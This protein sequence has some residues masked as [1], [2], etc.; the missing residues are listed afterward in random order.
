MTIEVVLP[1]LHA[2]QVKIWNERGKFNAVRCGRRFGKTK[3]LVTSGGNAAVKGRKAGIFTPEHKQWSEPY[4]ELL[5]ALAPIKAAANKTDGLIRTTTGG[6]ID[7]WSLNDNELAGRGREYD[8]LLV[9]E[10]AFT[11]NG[12]MMAIWDKSIRP[13]TL[14]KPKATAW[15][16]STPNG[17]DPD[18]FFWK[19]C[20]DE[21][22]KTEF[23]EHYAPSIA[24]P[25]V[26]PE[27]LE[28]HRRNN[29]PLVFQQE[30][31][32]QF[33]DFS[34][35]SFFSP[36]RLLVEGK[37]VEF[38]AGCDSVFA[39]ID[40]AVKQGQDHDG[41]AVSYWATSEWGTHKLIC[42]DWD[43]VSIDGALLEA[44]IPSVFSRAV[45]LAG[46]CKARYGATGVYIEDAQ[47]G[48]ILLQQCALRGL[49]AEALPAK[50][51]SAGKDAR[52]INASGPVWRGEVK[53]SRPAHKKTASF[54]GAVRNHF[55]SQV[56]GFRVGD[57]DAARRSDDLFDTFCYA[58]AIA[59]G[60]SDGYA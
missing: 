29:H 7:F 18:N 48:A 20:N 33:V 5:A 46:Q 17:I 40:T 6:L 38:P 58:V 43:I 51:T 41:T 25:L 2:G 37:P 21:E 53:I 15:V 14:T 4:G 31:L 54:K 11:K 42:L 52:A 60:N 9:D 28:R 13:T 12:Q 8:L 19:I 44:W 34:G 26:T 32:A 50:L 24:N 47:S 35:E 49:A 27:E 23:K 3:M 10:G 55:W 1:T 57:K 16:F 45:E 36:E 59:C 56:T 39:I 30:Y 22:L